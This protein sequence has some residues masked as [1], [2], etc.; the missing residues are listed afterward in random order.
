MFQQE[1]YGAIIDNLAIL[2]FYLAIGIAILRYRLW[3]IDVIIRRTLQYSLVTGR[4]A[5]VDFGSVLLG[6]RLTGALMAIRIAP[7][8]GGFDPVG[9][10]LVQPAPSPVQDFIERRF[11]RRKYD[12]EKALPGSPRPSEMNWIW[13]CS[14]QH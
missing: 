13:N 12:A 2:P 3:D 1:Y 10:G 14:V 7:G 9:C 11:Y 6:K 4:L 8:A 5:L